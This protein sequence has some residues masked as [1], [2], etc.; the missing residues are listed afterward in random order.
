MKVFICQP[1]AG[2]TDE[3]IYDERCKAVE[4]LDSHGYE[5]AN[6]LFEFDAGW[7]DRIG[8]KNVP[9]YYLAQSLE[10][11]SKCDAVYYCDG[12]ENARGCQIEHAAATAYGLVS[13]FWQE[14]PKEETTND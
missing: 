2:K 13:I 8:V 7:L 14:Y 3:E 10:V 9:L 1:M 12:W 11:M 5:V 6:S 4:F